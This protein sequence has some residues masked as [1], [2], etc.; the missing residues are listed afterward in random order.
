MGIQHLVLVLKS[1]HCFLL[2]ES[3]RDELYCIVHKY[4]PEGNKKQSYR[5]PPDG[6]WP[7]R[8]DQT[9]NPEIEVVSHSSEDLPLIL[10]L[11]F[12]EED[13]P[14]MSRFVVNILRNTAPDFIPE[15]ADDFLGVLYLVWMTDLSIKWIHGMNM[16]ELKPDQTFEHSVDLLI[17]G[18][19]HYQLNFQLSQQLA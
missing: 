1:I 19:F 14:S 13:I 12:N 15:L 6:Y 9:I 3:S 17:P 7:I 10:G 18:Q 5:L 8:A 11:N 2:Q 16:Y 4:D